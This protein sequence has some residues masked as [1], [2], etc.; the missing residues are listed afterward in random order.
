MTVLVF[1]LSMG[2]FLD[3][4]ARQ[5]LVPGIPFRLLLSMLVN[6]IPIILIYAIPVGLL[7]A[8]LL[9]FGRLSADGEIM[10][11]KACGISLISATRPLRLIGMAMT[12]LCLSL[13]TR[14]I[15]ENNYRRRQML[16]TLGADR[17]SHVITDGDFIR[18]FPGLTLYV[19]RK[20]GT[21]LR[22]IR[23][24]E[25]LRTGRSREIRAQTGRLEIDTH[26]QQAFLRLFHV[27]ITTLD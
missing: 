5:L 9:T 27:R 24:Y 16:A 4:S 21:T 17:V 1:V 2:L 11:M 8:S 20:K 22:D 26:R 12:L 23:I 25:T 7:V 6:G 10:A 14:L 3:R 13:A 15:P 19:G 18:A